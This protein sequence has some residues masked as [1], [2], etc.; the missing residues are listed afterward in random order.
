MRLFNTS[1]TKL[2]VLGLII[3]GSMSIAQC[4]A[5]TSL[6]NSPTFQLAS[7]EISAE[8]LLDIGKP[9]VAINGQ[10]YRYVLG[11]AQARAAQF[12]PA[13]AVTVISLKGYIARINGLA[14][15]FVITEVEVV[16]AQG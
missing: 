12:N 7:S 8:A 2:S 16:G 10:S 5:E 4:R 15:I 6:T 1:V 14:P 9:E 3:V 13:G 11:T